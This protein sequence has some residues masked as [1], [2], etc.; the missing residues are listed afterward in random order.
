MNWFTQSSLGKFKWSWWRLKG[1]F[2][3]LRKFKTSLSWCSGCTRF[4]EQEGSSTGLKEGLRVPLVPNFHQD[5]PSTKS[6]GRSKLEVVPGVLQ[7]DICTL[8][9]VGH[10]DHPEIYDIYC[11]WA[12]SCGPSANCVP[13]VHW[14]NRG[15]LEG[16]QG[17]FMRFQFSLEGFWGSMRRQDGFL[18]SK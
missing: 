3:S 16:V 10:V 6:L 8:E 13:I 12:G 5:E 18:R 11:L 15:V 1:T 14:E 17:F 7:T 9:E 2:Q 4:Q